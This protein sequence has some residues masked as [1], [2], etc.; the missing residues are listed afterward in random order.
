MSWIDG[1]EID[2]LQEVARAAKAFQRWFCSG[3]MLGYKEVS[4]HQMELKK[5]WQALDEYEQVRIKL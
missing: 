3:P 4:P 5:L 1:Y 2:A